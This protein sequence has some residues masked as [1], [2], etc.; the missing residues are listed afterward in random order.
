MEVRMEQDLYY[1]FE[2]DP[3]E[4]KDTEKCEKVADAWVAKLEDGEWYL[5]NYS[6]IMLQEGGQQKYVIEHTWT[7][8]VKE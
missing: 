8:E 7:K 1:C 5:S 3:E 4:S 2:F 6:N